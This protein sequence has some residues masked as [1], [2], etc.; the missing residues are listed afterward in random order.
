MHADTEAFE[1]GRVKALLDA[2][3]G[4]AQHRFAEVHDLADKLIARRTHHGPATRQILDE[5]QIADRFELQVVL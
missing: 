2:G 5:S 3:H 4:H 1:L